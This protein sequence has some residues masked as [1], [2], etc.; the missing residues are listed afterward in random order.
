M[1]HCAITGRKQWY[2]EFCHIQE[3]ILSAGIYLTI[4]TI[5]YSAGENGSGAG[6][7]KLT[8]GYSTEES[9]LFIIVHACRS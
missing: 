9:R 2:L 8:I 5:F 7:V 3:T 1:S 6:Q 4:Q